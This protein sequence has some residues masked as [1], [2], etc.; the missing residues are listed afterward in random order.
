MSG[1][2]AKFSVPQRCT[3]AAAESLKESA[4][5]VLAGKNEVVFD[6]EQVNTIDTA[7]LQVVTALY[8]ALKQQ[9]R[10]VI[11]SNLSSEFERAVGLC[12]LAEELEI[13]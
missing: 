2:K 6:V 13:A 4:D 8:R 12:G 1:R 5:K 11:W 9:E 10:G 3:I 7:G